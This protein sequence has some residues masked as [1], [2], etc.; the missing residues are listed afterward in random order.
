MVDGGFATTPPPTPPICFFIHLSPTQ[1]DDSSPW[2][3]SG[4]PG[5]NAVNAR[6]SS[7]GGRCEGDEEGHLV[8]QAGLVMKGRCRCRPV[9]VL[10]ADFKSS[11]GVKSV[12]TQRLAF[13]ARRRA[14]VHAGNGSVW[15]S[16]GVHR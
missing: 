11:A 15:K 6:K 9:P 4:R 3:A 5:D 12:E 16:G 10:G 2:P 13:V 8:Y 7:E 1:A 14:G